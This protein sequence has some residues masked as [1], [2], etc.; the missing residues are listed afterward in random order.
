MSPKLSPSCSAGSSPSTTEHKRASPCCACFPLRPQKPPFTRPHGIRTTF[1]RPA[2]LQPRPKAWTSAGRRCRSR[3]H[4]VHAALASQM[5]APLRVV[6]RPA[7]R[8]AQF[9]TT[10]IDP[11]VG[12]EPP[13]QVAWRCAAPS[14]SISAMTRRTAVRAGTS[15]RAV[16]ALTVYVAARL[17]KQ[18]AVVLART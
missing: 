12:V 6:P 18:I 7:G 3:T 14:A 16:S 15:A 5:T 4:A 8:G 17:G 13:V 11:A 1:G 9:A 2:F 10:M